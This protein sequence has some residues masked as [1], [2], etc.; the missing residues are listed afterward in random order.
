M[1]SLSERLVTSNDTGEFTKT[2]EYAML[3]CGNITANNNKYYC[4]E[5]QENPGSKQYRLFC[6]RGRIG[7]T[8]VYGVRG[9]LDD[10]DSAKK[11]YDKIV[12]SKTRGKSGGDVSRYTKI[13]VVKPTVGSKNICEQSVF[14]IKVDKPDLRDKIK[15]H[16]GKSESRIVQQVYEE[17]IHQISEMTTIN[18]TCNGLET[19]LGP[20]TKDHVSSARNILDELKTLKDRGRLEFADSRAVKLNNDYLSMI[21]RKIGASIQSSDM[22][23]SDKKLME[24]FDLLDQLEAAVQINA[25]DKKSDFAFGFGL[26]ENPGDLRRISGLFEKTRASNHSSLSG[27]KVKSVFDIEHKENTARFDR[28]SVGGEVFTLW[29]GSRNCN[30]LSIMMNGLI[31]PRY[32]APNVT[33]RMYGD[34][35]YAAHNS[36]KALNYST[37]YWAG[38]NNKYTNAFL[39]VVQF[40][41]GNIYFPKTSLRNGPPKGY[42]S[43]HAKKG[44]ASLYNDEYIVYSLNQQN[45]LQ[46]VE[47]ERK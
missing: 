32:N 45:I 10:Y 36:T 35:I 2:L 29:H 43:V 4:L 42:D 20:V 1:A 30:V 14:S 5:L 33:G 3:S 34:G 13:E 25:D 8:T 18:V 24:E 46:L 37:G 27:W 26:K 21:P 38:R 41:M 6:T 12:A 7:S 19:A 28:C 11:E 31:I 22:V 17:N 16:F 44:T 15:K 23:L 47:L 39:L 40:K 9:P